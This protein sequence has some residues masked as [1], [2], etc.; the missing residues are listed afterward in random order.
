MNSI[1][2]L[3]L[4]ETVMAEAN[5]VCIWTL[6]TSAISISFIKQWKLDKDESANAE[7]ATISAR[8]PR[9]DQGVKCLPPAS[10]APLEPVSSLL[11]IEAYAVRSYHTYNLGISPDECRKT[12]RHPKPDTHQSPPFEYGSKLRTIAG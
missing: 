4:D 1:A 9:Q 10:L 2:R 8:H 12:N 7:T 5:H 6:H 3:V 11:L